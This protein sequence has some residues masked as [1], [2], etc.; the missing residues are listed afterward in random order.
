MEFPPQVKIAVRAGG[1]LCE[2]EGEV[3]G[4]KAR[5]LGG[6]GG[7]DEIALRGVY[8]VLQTLQCRNDA[9]RAS[10]FFGQGRYV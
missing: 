5:D 2:V 8:D 9:Y 4:D 1:C 10:Q 7:V 3:G 6:Y